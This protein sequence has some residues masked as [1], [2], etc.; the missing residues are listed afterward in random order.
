MA[1]GIIITTAGLADIVTK[2]ILTGRWKPG[3][4]RGK[5]TASTLKKVNDTSHV[6]RTQ[7]SKGR[8]TGPERRRDS[9]TGAAISKRAVKEEKKET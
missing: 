2:R 4:G 6:T 8:E 7:C 5:H 3:S 9:E 1:G